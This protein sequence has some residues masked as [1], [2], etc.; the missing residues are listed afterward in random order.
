MLNPRQLAAAIDLSIARHRAR[1]ATAVHRVAEH[2]LAT[3]SPED[4]KGM[5]PEVLEMIVAARARRPG[6]ARIAG[7]G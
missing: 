6:E 2:L 3:L 4:R 7:G 1:D 5:N